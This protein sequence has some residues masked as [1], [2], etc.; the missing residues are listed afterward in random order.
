MFV[1]TV[2]FR[3]HPGHVEA[4]M[5]LVLNQARNSL[6]R[7]PGCQIFEVCQ[8]PETPEEIFLYEVYNDRAAFED[9]IASEHYRVFDAAVVD[10]AAGK[11]VRFFDRR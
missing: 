9:H 5:S 8:S 10:L 7:E 2:D 11:R 4:F 1:V 6:S 3:V